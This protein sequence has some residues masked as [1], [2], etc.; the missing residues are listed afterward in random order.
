MFITK[1]NW[2][3]ANGAKWKWKRMKIFE[4]VHTGIAWLSVNWLMKNSLVLVLLSLSFSFFLKINGV[5][6][7]IFEFENT[8]R[9]LHHPLANEDINWDRPGICLVLWLSIWVASVW[10]DW[11][12]GIMDWWV[13]CFIF[14]WYWVKYLTFL[15]MP[16]GMKRSGY[17]AR[18]CWY[19]WCCVDGL[20]GSSGVFAYLPLG[21]KAGD[22][23]L[24][25]PVLNVDIHAWNSKKFQ[26]EH[27]QWMGSAEKLC[28]FSRYI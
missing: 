3:A 6:I 13:G 8:R 2:K 10:L 27:S 4:S 12:S 1:L 23:A 19:F 16:D 26:N 28:D 17:A 25:A 20:D 11:N 21:R 18:I 14:I 9:L 5:K 22:V 24:G 15:S 7:S